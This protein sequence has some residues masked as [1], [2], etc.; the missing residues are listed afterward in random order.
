MSKIDYYYKKNTYNYLRD[1]L[2]PVALHITKISK[3]KMTRTFMADKPNMGI[4]HISLLSKSSILF[5]QSLSP[6]IH[7]CL[8]VMREDLKSST[9]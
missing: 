7:I 6:N 8:L 3:A 1:G 5:L 4:T 9:S 2:F